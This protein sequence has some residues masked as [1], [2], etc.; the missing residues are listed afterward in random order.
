[1]VLYDV[2]SNFRHTALL[3][4]AHCGER[5]TRT[6][7]NVCPLKEA[8]PLNRRISTLF[9]SLP[10][11]VGLSG[12]G[13]SSSRASIPSSATLPSS[14]TS[15]IRVALEHQSPPV[16]ILEPGAGV[17]PWVTLID[18]AH[19]GIDLNAYLMDNPAILTALRQAGQRGIPIHV[20]LAPNPYDDTAAVPQ[21]RQALST[22]PDATVRN[23]P[24]RF[25]Q[26]YAFDHAKYLV[27]NPGT[28]QTTAILGSPN[29]TDSAF[30]GT[31][32]EAAVQVTGTAAQAVAQ[33]FRADWTDR[34]AGSGPRQTLVLSPGATATWLQ[35]LRS[36]GLIQM[37]TEE[38]GDDPTVLS[39][40]ARK[41]SDLQL[42]CPAPSSAAAQSSLATLAQAGV[43][44]RTL[45][46]PY[47]HAKTIITTQTAFLGSQN[48]SSMSLQDN[49][50]LGVLV[51]GTARTALATWFQH[52]WAQASPWTAVGASS[53]TL[54]IDSSRPWLPNDASMATVRRLW[55]PPE[56]IYR[57]TYHG[58]AQIAWVYPVSGMHGLTATV[59]FVGQR[60]V[61][62]AT[63]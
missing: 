54:P 12:C 37:T 36:P 27:I 14:S 23:A 2:T 18:Q 6:T 21:E 53:T 45:S 9:I 34:A 17:T 43:K 13:I 40:M 57:T 52:W 50:E 8:I 58:Q 33:V 24:P 47:V 42:L 1:M 60:I 46:A 38:I 3:R 56:R 29:F 35:L 4:H 26:A 62:V 49:R 30:D 19:T 51:S 5:K 11:I 28:V 61:D 39:A 41:E 59:Y 22:I 15:T 20:I 48:L 31:N 32:M 44:I 10:V 63:R 55:G 7:I 16:L 25:D